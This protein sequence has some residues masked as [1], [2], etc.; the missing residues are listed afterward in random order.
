MAMIT[1][2]AKV[3][4]KGQIAIPL[5]I[6]EKAGI[7]KGDELI[8]IQEGKKILLESATNVRKHVKE[9][10]SDLL[11]LSEKSLMKVWDNKADAAWDK[12]FRK[13]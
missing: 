5:D 4:Q 11:K 2:T 8:I 12:Y 7:H 3:S 6:R 10:F 13:K 9:D 1:K